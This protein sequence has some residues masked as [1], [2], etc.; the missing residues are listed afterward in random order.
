MI[1]P[2]GEAMERK[3]CKNCRRCLDLNS[4]TKNHGYCKRKACQRARKRCWQRQKMSSDPD[5]RENQ[6]NA[7]ITWRENNPDYW[8]KYRREHEKYL[9]RNRILQKKRDANR[10][11][12]HLAKMD[13]SSDKT[14][15]KQGGYYYIIPASSDLAKMDAS[16]QKVLLIPDGYKD[17]TASCKE[18]LDLQADRLCLGCIKKE[19][20]ADD[21][22]TSPRSSP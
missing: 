21:L 2:W 11:A 22:S 14:Q 7:Q 16:A 6:K 1:F 13:A 5:Y 8:R 15:I 19:T 20:K 10:R 3:R 18:G 4:H 9:Q 12:R 17:F